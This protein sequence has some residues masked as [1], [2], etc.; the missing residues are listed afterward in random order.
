MVKI[1]IFG[2]GYVG[3][4]AGVCFAKYNHKVICVD[5]DKEKIE[6]LKTGDPVI[7]EPGL[8]EVLDEACNY[9]EKLCFCILLLETHQL[10]NQECTVKTYQIQ[11]WEQLYI[12]RS[13]IESPF[14]ANYV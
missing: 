14:L 13:I 6:R 8:K 10:D 7:Y 9:L 4:I 1:S 2:T 3:L 11:I 5:I 12:Q